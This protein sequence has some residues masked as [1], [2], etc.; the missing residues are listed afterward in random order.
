MIVEKSVLTNAQY[1]C[2]SATNTAVKFVEVEGEGLELFLRSKN[3]V[4]REKR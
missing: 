1:T 2:T 4:S 3:L